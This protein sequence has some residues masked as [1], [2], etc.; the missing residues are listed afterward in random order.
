MVML[1]SKS[2]LLAKIESTYGTDPT[3]TGAANALLVMDADIKENITP[4][5]REVQMRTLGM[6][7]ALKGDS[8][9]DIT[10]KVEAYGSGTAGTAPRVGTLLQACGLAVTNTPGTS[11][12]YA[13]TS[14]PTW[15]CTIYLYKDGRLHIS[16]G[17][18][19]NAKFNFAAGKLFSIEFSF[20][21]LYTAPS[22]AALPSTTYEAN[23]EKPP[24]CMTSAFTYNSKTTLVTSEVTFD[25]GNNI[26]MRPS[27]SATTGVAGFYI[28]GRKPVITI[29]PESQIETS[30]AF[31][32]DMLNG[33]MKQ[34]SIV[35]TRAAG[36]IFTLTVPKFN[37]TKIEYG[38]RD[39][40]LIEKIEGQ[41]CDSTT[42]DDAFTF[43]AT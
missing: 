15:S 31:R 2:V 34:I 7:P 42:G 4:L 28:T 35:A 3:P 8:S 23:Y 21:G 11:D 12:S 13:P 29:D 38:D 16:T 20:K 17:C 9:V 39:N 5:E 37:I 10:F 43:V 41:A 25:L 6:P 32:T 33:A 26:V 1:K 36:N 24:V 14:T 22:N 18:V 19:G 40:V 27:L 30:Y